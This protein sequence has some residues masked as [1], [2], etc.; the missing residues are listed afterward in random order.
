MKKTTCRLGT[1]V[2]LYD[3]Q[4]AKPKGRIPKKGVRYVNFRSNIKDISEVEMYFDPDGILTIRV[5]KDIP[6]S[7]C[8]M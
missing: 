7:A 4:F 6:V 5:P 8:T 2:R 3:P 1:K